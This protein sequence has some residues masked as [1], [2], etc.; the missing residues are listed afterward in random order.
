[1]FSVPVGYP[2]QE[3]EREIVQRTTVGELP[4]A[5]QVVT[6]AELVAFQ[7]LIRRMPA[8]TDVVDYAVRLAS[9]TRPGSGLDATKW[10]RWGAGPRASQFLALGAR[11]RAALDGRPSSDRRDVQAVAKAVLRHRVLL[12]F[13]AE[14]AGITADQVVDQ[15]LEEIG[16]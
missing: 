11:A 10:I 15:V 7:Q 3:E 12:N 2:S 4:S 9:A 1:M 6:G 13:E 16:S 8:S 14:A 5:Q